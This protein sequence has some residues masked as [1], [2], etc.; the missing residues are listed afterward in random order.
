[1]AAWALSLSLSACD[2]VCD[3]VLC[4]VCRCGRGVCVWCGV[5]GGGGR[6]EKSRD[7]SDRIT[8]T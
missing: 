5:G 8:D 3:A 2:V 6:R 7:E 4:C 1:M